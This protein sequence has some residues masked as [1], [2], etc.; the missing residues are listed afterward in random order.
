MPARFLKKSDTTSG[1]EFAIDPDVLDPMHAAFGFG[2][3]ICPGR[4]MAY[5]LLW[6]TVASVLAT[7]DIL[8]AQ[9]A[10]GEDVVPPETYTH[11][12]IR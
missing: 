6:I 5:E 12:F 3:R 11:G 9:D 10:N 7:F 2:R 1:P 4:Y 8:R